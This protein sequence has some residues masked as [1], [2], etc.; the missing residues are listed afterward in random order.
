MN[1]YFL[2]LGR[3]EGISFLALLFIAMP[4]KYGAQNPFYVQLLGP[5]HGFLFLGYCFWAFYLALEHK[6]PLQKHLL[7]YVAAVFPFGTFMFEKK[8][9]TLL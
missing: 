5:I 4:M 3:L 9:R 6:W 8:Y 7:A 2:V 1:K